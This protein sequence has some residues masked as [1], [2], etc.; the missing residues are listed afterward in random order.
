MIALA[1]LS[2]SICISLFI[3]TIFHSSVAF[4]WKVTIGTNY[5][6]RIRMISRM[7]DK[8]LFGD[9][10]NGAGLAGPRIYNR[11]Y[12][13]AFS[14]TSGRDGAV[15]PNNARFPK[16]GQTISGTG[17]FVDVILPSDVTIDFNG[18]PM[19]QRVTFNGFSKEGGSF[20]R[21]EQKFTFFPEFE[22]NENI[23]IGTKVNVGS[24]RN[25]YFQASGDDGAG[26]PPFGEWFASG[27]N[28]GGNDTTAMVSWEGVSG[29]IR[30]P[31]GAL[32]MK[33]KPAW[34]A[35]AT[36]GTNVEMGDY[37]LAV[38]YGPMTFAYALWL[39]KGDSEDGSANSGDSVANNE[40]YHGFFV[41]FE[42]RALS[43]GAGLLW[44]QW[45]SPLSELEGPDPYTT[46][47]GNA[48]ADD[49][50]LRSGNQDG[51][52]QAYCVYAKYFSPHFF[53]SAEFAWM[54]QDMYPVV[55]GG[56]ETTG[57]RWAARQ[58]FGANFERIIGI[59]KD[60][61]A[62]EG[63]QTDHPYNFALRDI[64]L[65][66]YHLFFEAGI[67]FGPAKWS[68]MWAQAS[69]PVLNNRNAWLRAITDADDDLVWDGTNSLNNNPKV[70][71][72][73]PINPIALQSYQTILFSE[74]A[75]G[76]QGG[77]RIWDLGFCRDSG[78]MMTDAV[79]LGTRLDYA[80]AANLNVWAS[81]LHAWRLEKYGTFF[82]QYTAA[83]DSNSGSLGAGSDP[84]NGRI[85]FQEACGLA[86]PEISHYPRS[87]DLGFE[88]NLGLHWQ[89]L[90][91]L[92]FMCRYSIWK[93]G[94]WFNDAYQGW[95]DSSF[96]AGSTTISD[97]PKVT[98][99]FPVGDRSPIHCFQWGFNLSL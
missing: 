72:S 89:L 80:I 87:T 31:W 95:N 13:G 56:T 41:D 83:G 61:G 91:D 73:F 40:F 33:P 50:R 51:V 66:A 79:C 58:K 60:T 98:N 44:R 34:G 24:Q 81:Y 70:Y 15:K 22:L 36:F 92:D 77:S 20:L 21:N 67:L 39:N 47:G 16:T 14:G 42:N 63:V 38:P 68:F 62:A 88:I 86:N 12:L 1:R 59:N 27:D 74:Y 5:Q 10:R 75:G 17:G 6:N 9:S 55:A 65:E 85:G 52:M 29:S 94:K 54:T 57:A 4:A 84:P 8:D 26:E 48:A 53:L 93:P 37:L 23:S 45:H 99:G 78:G 69:G 25:K 76:N 3:L 18:N 90:E 11:G 2:L 43:V 64:H 28:E 35:G 71:G 30:T 19:G 32:V 82:G 97:D 96:F 49:R 46:P 7:G